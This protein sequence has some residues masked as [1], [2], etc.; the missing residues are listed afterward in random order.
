VPPQP[1]SPSEN[2]ED[3]QK[4]IKREDITYIKRNIK[5]G[6]TKKKIKTNFDIY[7]YFPSLLKTFNILSIQ[8]QLYLTFQLLKFFLI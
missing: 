7:N 8:F 3:R 4:P 1:N 6:M 2:V 5:S